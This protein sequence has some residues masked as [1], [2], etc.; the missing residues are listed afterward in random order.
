MALPGGPADKIGNRY[1]RRWAALMMLDVLRGDANA[2]RIEVPGE[3]GAG[4][5]FR[6][7][8]EASTE[9][10]QCKAGPQRWTVHAL[11]ARA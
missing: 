11:C 4:F 7:S 9:W 6:L 2:I 8:R 10:H 3:E 5:E 1:E